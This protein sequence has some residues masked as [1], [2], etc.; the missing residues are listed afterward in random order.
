MY[1]LLKHKCPL[2]KV[3]VF[4]HEFPDTTKG[5]MKLDRNFNL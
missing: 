1:I 5:E 3:T 2:V 4:V